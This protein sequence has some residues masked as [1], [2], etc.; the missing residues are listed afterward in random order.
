MD[1]FFKKKMYDKSLVCFHLVQFFISIQV[2]HSNKQKTEPTQNQDSRVYCSQIESSSKSVP[3][4]F[5]FTRLCRSTPLS[6]FLLYKLHLSSWKLI[7]SIGFELSLSACEHIFKSVTNGAMSKVCHLQRV[8]VCVISYLLLW[9]CCRCWT[10]A[11]SARQA[12][13]RRPSPAAA[14]A[15]CP[16]GWLTCSP[17]VCPGQCHCVLYLKVSINGVKKKWCCCCL[18]Y[19]VSMIKN[20]TKR[21]LKCQ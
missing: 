17:S 5:L 11:P 19:S 9:C 20:K 18:S 14:P 6:T 16:G 1:K 13:W 12:V 10:V 7:I 4:L 21:F 15:L 8:F 3:F 2:H